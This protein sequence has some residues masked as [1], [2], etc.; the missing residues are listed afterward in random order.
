MGLDAVFVP[1]GG[2]GLSSGVI[3]G[4]CNQA[5]T[6]PVFGAE[7]LLGNDAARSLRQNRLVCNET[8]PMTIADGARTISL[9]R[10][11]WAVI[12][13]GIADIVEVPDSAI[14]QGVRLLAQ[15]GVRVEPTG[16]LSVGSLLVGTIPRG[17]RVGCILSGGNVDNDVYH[18]IIG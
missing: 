12:R 8:E 15:D 4:L 2:G 17:G 10:H 3:T 1:I 6:T 14:E 13:D 16:A 9:G 11:N 18:R 5:D 7:P